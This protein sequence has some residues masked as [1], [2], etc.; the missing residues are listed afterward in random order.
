[1]TAMRARNESRTGYELAAYD[2]AVSPLYED[3]LSYYKGTRMKIV[4]QLYIRARN[5][6][7]N[8]LTYL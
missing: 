2:C 5:G 1:M 8:V 7:R 3:L 4:A 6:S